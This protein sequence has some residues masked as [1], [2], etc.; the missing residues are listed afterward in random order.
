MLDALEKLAD[1]SES[2]QADAMSMPKAHKLILRQVNV[3]QARKMND[4]DKLST[5]S[6]AI[7]EGMFNGLMVSS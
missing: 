4:G 6:K 5:A 3:F 1:L 2:L 7:G